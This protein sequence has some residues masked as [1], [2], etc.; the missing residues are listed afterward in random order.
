MKTSRFKR[1]RSS[2]SSEIRNRGRRLRFAAAIAL[3]APRPSIGRPSSAAW[4]FLVTA[5]CSPR[6]RDD[7]L[8]RLLVDAMLDVDI[9]KDLIEKNSD[10]CGKA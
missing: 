7:N 4:M 9:L 6:G 10:A 1:N 3:E 2:I 5:A 8:K